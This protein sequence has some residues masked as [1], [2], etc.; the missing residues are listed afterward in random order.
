MHISLVFYSQFWFRVYQST[1]SIITL[2]KKESQDEGR[3]EV[4]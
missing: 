2:Q 4:G 3:I 1:P